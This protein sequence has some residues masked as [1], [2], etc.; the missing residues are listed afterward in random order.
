[1][2]KSRR[3]TPIVGNTIAESEKK[4]KRLWNKK[5]RRLSNQKIKQGDEPPAD[6]R[7][8]TEVW[9]GEKDGKHWTDADESI[10]RK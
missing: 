4:D 10:M 8:V 9:S 5:F 7:E 1:M 3:K 2:S 6:I